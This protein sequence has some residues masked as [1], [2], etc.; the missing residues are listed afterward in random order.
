MDDFEVWRAELLQRG[1]PLFCK[2]NH[3]VKIVLLNLH[4]NQSFSVLDMMAATKKEQAFSFSFLRIIYCT[5]SLRIVS[6]VF[7]LT[8]HGIV[9]IIYC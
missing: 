4:K 6:M 7:N 5:K 2:R 9:S 1:F 8:N 3:E